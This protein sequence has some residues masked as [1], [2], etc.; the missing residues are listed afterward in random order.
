MYIAAV[1]CSVVLAL[2]AVGSG[3][4]KVQLRGQV[5][6]R[7]RG[8]G[9]SARTVRIVGAVELVIAVLLVAGLLFLP[10]TIFACVAFGVV[11]IWAVGQ[12]VTYGDYGNP[13]SQKEAFIPLGALGFTVLTLVIVIAAS[14]G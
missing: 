2:A 3:L 10:V 13:D 4:P 1:V 6:S 14:G 11:L 7:L 8:R 12:H 5:W 9:F